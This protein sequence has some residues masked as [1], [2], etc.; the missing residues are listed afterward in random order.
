MIKVGHT[1]LGCD[2][3]QVRPEGAIKQGI[4]GQECPSDGPCWQ[5][6]KSWSFWGWA[7]TSSSLPG[8]N[9]SKGWPAAWPLLQ[10]PQ[11]GASHPGCDFPAA[12][13]G[14]R[15]GRRSTRRPGEEVCPSDGP[16]KAEAEFP[17]SSP[18][19]EAGSHS[20]PGDLSQKVLWNGHQATPVAICDSSILSPRLEG[21]RQHLLHSNSFCSVGFSSRSSRESVCLRSLLPSL[22]SFSL[23]QLL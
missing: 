21:R 18:S 3:Q 20:D 2:L 17:Q 13:P 19:R 16:T 12:V 23:F 7:V 1:G 15:G 4:E 9:S 22:S 8:R 14:V 11:G 10:S 5:R 6:H